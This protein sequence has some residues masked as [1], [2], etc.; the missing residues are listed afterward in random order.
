MEESG[1]LVLYKQSGNVYDQSRN[2]T[3]H[4]TRTSLW[5]SN[6]TGEENFL[7][8]KDD[9]VL[10]IFDKNNQQIWSSHTN[11]SS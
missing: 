7:V 10:V 9:G 5:Q 4:S 1:N 8:L 6:T 11:N 3:L 2:I